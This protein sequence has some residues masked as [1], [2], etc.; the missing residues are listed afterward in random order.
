MNLHKN[1]IINAALCCLILG[2]VMWVSTPQVAAQL[3]TDVIS[4]E[5]LKIAINK[6]LGR[7]APY[8]QAIS[9]ANL[10]AGTFTQLDA[11]GYGKPDGE[12]IKDLAGL[13]HATNLTHLDLSHNA[14][15]EGEY[16]HQRGDV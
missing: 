1:F 4:D 16:H 2:V 3:Q 10:S 9:Q 6:A 14:L 5:N 15:A 7:A 13:Q 11:S 12:K 8:N